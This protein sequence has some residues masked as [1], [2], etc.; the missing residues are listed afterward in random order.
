MSKRF[1]SIFEATVDLNLFLSIA[2]GVTPPLAFFV[3]VAKGRWVW[4]VNNW[5]TLYLRFKNL[6]NGDQALEKAL[7]DLNNLVLS[8]QLGSPING[9]SN[10][11]N[12]VAFLPLL[13]NLQLSEFSLTTDEK[14]IVAQEYARINSFDITDFLNMADFISQQI[15]NAADIIGMGDPQ[16]SVIYSGQTLEK[17]REPTFDDLLQ[18]EALIE[19]EQTIEGIVFAFKQKQSRPPDLL[20]VAS[21]NLSSSSGVSIHTA[22]RSYRSVPFFGS[23]EQMASRYLGDPRKWFEL[24]TVNDLQPPFVDEYGTKY[25]L[26]APGSASSVTIDNSQSPQVFIGM[27][28]RVGSVTF[29]EEY[30]LVT[31]LSANDD[32]SLTLFLSGE[33]NLS[34]LLPT[35]NA[36]VRIYAPGTITSGSMV[37]IPLDVRSSMPSVLTPT[38]DVLRQLDKSLLAFG[39]DILRD[40]KTGDFLTDSTGN[41]QYAVGLQNIQQAIYWRLRTSLGQLPF[42]PTYGIDLAIGNRY[43]GNESEVTKLANA[44][45]QSI[46]S[47]SRFRQVEIT[48]FISTG[49]GVSIEMVVRVGD[50]TLLLPLSF[51]A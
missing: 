27:K 10:D 38:S 29:R 26:L 11:Q 48:R 32:G 30:R 13:M 16:G 9:L 36:Y 50:S 17:Q 4:I 18:I 24:V 49:N 1:T 42:H 33:P 43:T 5:N 19:L 6:A 45:K 21:N 2:K 15:T 25:S 12:Y 51:A 34:R 46:L 39:V 35:Q 37:S 20:K 28:V 22:Y 3:A 14:K 8:Y 40:R 23:L 31:D 7:I 47:D 44:I 41:Y